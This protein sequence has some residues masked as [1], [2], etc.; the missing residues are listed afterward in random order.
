M[1][2]STTNLDSIPAAPSSAE[3]AAPRAAH[4]P[5]TSTW[6]T[7]EHALLASIWALGLMLVLPFLAPFH[8]PPIAS[9][10]PE[11]IAALFGLLAVSVLPL[12]ATR[13]EMPR[14]ALL[15]LGLRGADHGAARPGE[16]GIPPSRLAGYAL[17]AVGHGTDLPGRTVEARARTGARGR[18]ARV[19]RVGRR[20]AE[21]ARSLGPAYRQQRAGSAD[22]AARARAGLGESRSVQ[23]ACRL[24]GARSCRG[25]IPLRDRP[26]EAALGRACPAGV[27]LHPRAHGIACELGVLDR[28]DRGVGGFCSARALSVQSAVAG[29]QRVRASSRCR[30]CPGWLACCRSI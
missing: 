1:P 13:L 23:S 16:A 26:D 2:T 7:R 19:V 4:V 20:V 27:D 24:S 14:I 21:R 15:P 6:F 9:F 17:S 22:D 3:P 18:D 28:T 8:A 25:R 5:R 29:F 30:S 12:F 10:H 11:A